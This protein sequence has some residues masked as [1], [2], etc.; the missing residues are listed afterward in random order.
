MYKSIPATFEV[1]DNEFQILSNLVFL[2]F[3]FSA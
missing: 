1:I 2:V 3:R